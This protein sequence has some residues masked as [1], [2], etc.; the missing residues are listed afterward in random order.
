M[1]F[2]SCSAKELSVPRI[3]CNVVEWKKEEP[4]D[5]WKRDR[6]SICSESVLDPDFRGETV[7]LPG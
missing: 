1:V 5:G 2:R 6:G 4:V 3:P 7:M